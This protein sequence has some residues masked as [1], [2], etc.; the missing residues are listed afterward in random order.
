MP[1]TTAQLAQFANEWDQ[2]Q[3]NEFGSRLAKAASQT[4]RAQVMSDFNANLPEREYNSHPQSVQLQA[5]ARQ[6]KNLLFL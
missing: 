2:T 5:A 3:L 6:V 4:E 1:L